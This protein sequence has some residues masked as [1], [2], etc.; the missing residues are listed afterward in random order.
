MIEKKKNH[1]SLLALPSRPVSHYSIRRLMAHFHMD[2][3]LLHAGSGSARAVI[4]AVSCTVSTD[5]RVQL[6]SATQQNL[7]L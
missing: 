4:S 7:T 6:P 1:K 2:G 3:H 5:W